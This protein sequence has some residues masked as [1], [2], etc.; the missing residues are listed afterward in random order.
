MERE[1]ERAIS[2]YLEKV[3]AE[4]GEMP[5]DEKDA[6]LEGV[7]SHIYEALKARFGGEAT[8][9][10]LKAVLAEMA[11]PGSYA[12][13]KAGDASAATGR[14]TLCGHAMTAGLLLPLGFAWLALWLLLGRYHG[15]TE[16]F[17]DVAPWILFVLGA[18]GL[19]LT[20]VLGFAAISCIK[21]SNGKRT[22][23]PL[24][25]AAAF[26]Y[27]VLLMDAFI[28][29]CLVNVCVSAANYLNA[30]R[31]LFMLLAVA[32]TI[33]ATLIVWLSV[34]VFLRGWRWANRPLKEGE[35]T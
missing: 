13:P 11:P 22:G 16:A 19:T 3:A 18:A 31:V 21:A 20:P 8:A 2:V 17:R 26:T 5:A 6:V 35:F 27:P 7:E 28:V 33:A 30:N 32:T 10:G 9:E 25:V 14:A 24:A 1:I 34:W 4:L 15:L 12:A 29:V 23:L